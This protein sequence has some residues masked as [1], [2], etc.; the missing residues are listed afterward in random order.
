M[1]EPQVKIWK[2]GEWKNLTP[3]KVTKSGFSVMLDFGEKVKSVKVHIKFP[4]KVTAE[5]VELYEIE[6]LD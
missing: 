4:V 5:P 6:L 3:V 2:F 1:G